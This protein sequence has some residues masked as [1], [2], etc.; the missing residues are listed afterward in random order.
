MTPEEARQWAIPLWREDL[1]SSMWSESSSCKY[2]R[3]MLRPRLSGEPDSLRVPLDRGCGFPISSSPWSSSSYSSVARRLWMS[4]LVVR[5]RLLNLIGRSSKPSS[6]TEPK[7]L[8]GRCSTASTNSSSSTIFNIRIQLTWSRAASRQTSP[9]FGHGSQPALMS[10]LAAA[11][12]PVCSYRQAAAI[13]SGGCFG[14]DLTRE[15]KSIRVLLISPI[16]ASDLIATPS[17]DVRYPFGS[18]EVAIPEPDTW[19]SL[20]DRILS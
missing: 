2:M 8:L 17:R 4:S 5:R 15:S 20:S 3:E 10:Y 1:E 16:S 14:F 18:T 7:V 9:L 12:L 19:S 6:G 13:H 11:I